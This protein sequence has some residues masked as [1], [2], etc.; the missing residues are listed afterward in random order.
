MNNKPCAV[1]GTLES[2]DILI[3]I[4]GLEDGAPNCVHLESSVMAQ[5][6]DEIKDTIKACLAKMGLNSVS[7][8]A[9]DRGALECTIKARMEAAMN[10]YL[11]AIHEA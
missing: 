5:F 7:V 10:R 4:S 9:K 3:N 6:G 11:E 1:A 2:N 8:A